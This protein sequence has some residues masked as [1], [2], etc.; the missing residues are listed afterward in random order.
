M[1][2]FCAF[3]PIF[4]HVLMVLNRRAIAA[5]EQ[6]ALRYR[7]ISATVIAA[8]I[9]AAVRLAREPGIDIPSPR[10]LSTIFD[11]VGLARRILKIALL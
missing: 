8:A 2:N 6:A 10:V 9:I 1:S 3:R 5:D 11:S 4:A 7:F